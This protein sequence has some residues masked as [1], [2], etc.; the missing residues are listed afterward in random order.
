MSLAAL[1]AP[2]HGTL[3]GEDVEF[4]ELTTDTRALTPGSLFLALTG[5]NFD[6]NEFVAQAQT[7]GACGAIVSRQL[8]GDFPQLCVADTHKALGTIAALNRAR[9]QAAVVALTGSQGKTT[10]K[11]M[12]GA[13]LCMQ[14]AT[15]I[16]E[17]NLNNTIGV[18]LTLLRLDDGHQFAVVEM[19]ANGHG[20]IAFSVGVTQPDVALITNASAAHIE[21]FG[22]LQGI[23]QAKGEIIDG[24]KPDGT[25]VLNADDANCGIWQQRAAG[26]KTV[27]FSLLNKHG[28]AHFHARAIGI[29]ASA[30][31]TFTL[32]TPEG[33]KPVAMKLLGKHNITNAVAAAAA[34]MAAGASVEDVARGLGN[35]EPVKGRLC[36]L[37]GLQGSR[38]IDDTYNASP[39]SFN[40]AVDVLMCHA[41]PKYL[42]AGDMRELGDEAVSAHQSVGEYAARAGVDEL[43]AVG[44]LSKY[45]VGA[46]GSR[47]RHFDNKEA[48]VQACKK[49]AGPNVTFLV[50]GSRGARMDTVVSAL[51]TNEEV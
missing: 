24:L 30:H 25:M 19:G 31:T 43:L 23:V 41:G 37:S 5:E 33:E 48:L 51:T 11:E 22:S 49:L 32:V 12:L 26:K 20:E 46:A 44:E 18:P 40:A 29:D 27:L 15:L 34:A 9:S 38:L 4:S 6:G 36:P 10:V 42:V 21:G 17:A 3:T 35:V 7:S 16:T 14:G 2:L 47:A 39:S 8:E 13:I 28:K 45:M 50:K 1:A